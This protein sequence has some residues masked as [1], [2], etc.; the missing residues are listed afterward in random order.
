MEQTLQNNHMFI[1]IHFM[2][3]KS[4]QSVRETI[5]IHTNFFPS[6]QKQKGI[7]S[8]NNKITVTSLLYQ[9]NANDLT[10]GIIRKKDQIELGNST[11]LIK[12]L[13][14]QNIFKDKDDKKGNNI[15]DELIA[16]IL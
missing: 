6:Q 5:A 1:Y 15:M 12:N 14:M 11:L 4:W 13:K 3:K 8:F 9:L 16:E 10:E 7:I 2:Q